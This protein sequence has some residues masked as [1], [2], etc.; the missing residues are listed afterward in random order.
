MP[1]SGGLITRIYHHEAI[2]HNP[3]NILSEYWVVPSV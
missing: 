2:S 3:N 1:P